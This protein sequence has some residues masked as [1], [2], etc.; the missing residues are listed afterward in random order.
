MAK[1]IKYI[2]N[3]PHKVSHKYI[4]LHNIYFEIWRGITYGKE[5]PMHMQYP[6]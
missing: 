1:T 4:G 2:C 5:Y 3:T 6:L